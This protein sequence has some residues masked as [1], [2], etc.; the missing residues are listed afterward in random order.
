M[1]SHVTG[2]TVDPLFTIKISTNMKKF[3]VAVLLLLTCCLIGIVQSKKSEPGNKPDWAKKDVR[4]YSD[5]DLERL[6][7]QW[8]E[9]E[10]PLGKS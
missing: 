3:G 2:C 5:A 1:T 8:E 9:D 6:L 7:D 10:E 4:D